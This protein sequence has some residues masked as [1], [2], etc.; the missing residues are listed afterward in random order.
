MT[1]KRRFKKLQE[2]QG[3]IDLNVMPFI[4]VF[5]LLTTFLLFSAVFIQIGILEVQVPF[6]SNKVTPEDKP[7]RTFKIHVTVDEETIEVETF[8]TP[9]PRNSKTKKFGMNKRGMS[10]MHDYL[11]EIRS[12]HPKTDILSLFVDK[13][14]TYDNV[15]KLVDAIK[16]LNKNDPPLPVANE[17]SDESSRLSSTPNLT[18]YPKI[19]MGNVLFSD[20]D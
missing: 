11:I 3:P 1:R 16:F 15:I 10:R 8:Y 14:V 7:A 2:Y 9:D 5:S 20:Y 19:L 17:S 4:D 6:L 18:L 13:E 12:D